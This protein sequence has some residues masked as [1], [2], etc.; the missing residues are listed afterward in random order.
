MYTELQNVVLGSFHYAQRLLKK[1]S[2]ISKLTN[3]ARRLQ[4]FPD[5]KHSEPYKKKGCNNLLSLSAAYRTFK[6]NYDK[7]KKLATNLHI[8]THA[9]YM[10]TRRLNQRPNFPIDPRVVLIAHYS[11]AR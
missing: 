5:P 11:P 3:R 2:I 10:R 8:Y 7:K 6:K 4:F 9:R 1:S